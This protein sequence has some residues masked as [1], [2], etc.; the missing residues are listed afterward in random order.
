[1]R[2]LEYDIDVYVRLDL[3]VTI[4]KKVTF[5]IEVF[6]FLILTQWSISSKSPRFRIDRTYDTY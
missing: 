6:L 5:K 3:L 4:V 2:E 1:M